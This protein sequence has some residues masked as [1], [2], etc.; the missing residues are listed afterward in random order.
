LLEKFGFGTGSTIF[1]CTRVGDRSR[2]KAGPSLTP[3]GGSGGIRRRETGFHPYRSISWQKKPIL[4]GV[5]DK[6][7]QPGILRETFGRSPVCTGPEW[8][9]HGCGEIKQMY[10]NA[11]YGTPVEGAKV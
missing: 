8:F 6:P 2:E 3:G 11:Y 1:G 10:L 4:K 7:D 9:R 5:G